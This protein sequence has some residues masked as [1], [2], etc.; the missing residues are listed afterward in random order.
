M[1]STT[2]TESQHQQHQVHFSSSAPL[3]PLPD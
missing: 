2:T 1:H 3:V